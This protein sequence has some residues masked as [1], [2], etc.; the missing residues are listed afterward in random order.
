MVSYYQAEQDFLYS[1]PN[2]NTKPSDEICTALMKH[3]RFANTV[4]QANSEGVSCVSFC[5]EGNGEMSIIYDPV[6]IGSFA[7]KVLV[8]FDDDKQMSVWFDR[9]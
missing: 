5:A 8:T 1:V 9:N 3:K 2:N 6:Y 7:T 4:I